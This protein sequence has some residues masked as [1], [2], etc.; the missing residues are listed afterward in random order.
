[1]PPTLIDYASSDKWMS[2]LA[3]ENLERA[4]GEKGIK[5]NIRW[6]EGYNHNPSFVTTFIRE[7]IEF[8]AAKLN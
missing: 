7:H 5:V 4:F 6:Q 2:D 3:A 1:M 8:H